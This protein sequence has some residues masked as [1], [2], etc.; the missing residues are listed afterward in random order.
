VNLSHVKAVDDNFKVKVTGDTELTV[1]I[2]VKN[3][4]LAAVAD[5]A[6][7]RISNNGGRLL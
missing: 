2:R 1:A 4:F 5:N 7:S 6:I 3:D